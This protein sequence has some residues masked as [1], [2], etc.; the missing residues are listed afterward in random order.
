MKPD[1]A[2][3]LQKLPRVGPGHV[4]DAP[5]LTLP[6][7]QAI[8]V[9]L[10]HAVEMNGIDGDHASLSQAGQRR[11]HDLSTRSE[12]DRAVQCGRR[13]IVLGAHPSGAHRGCQLPMRS[14]SGGHKDLAVPGAQH[15]KG[16]VRGRSKAEQT[17]SL[18]LFD[19]RDAQAAVP[20]DTGAKQRSRLQ[21]VEVFWEWKYK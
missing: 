9:E 16:Q 18:A 3:D 12:S 13:A 4:G 2:R 15:R 6:P 11:E 1:L 5:D 8:V 20:D 17:H 14:A 7:Q 21:I 19:T 10:G